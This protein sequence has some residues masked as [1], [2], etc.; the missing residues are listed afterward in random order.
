MPKKLKGYQQVQ[1]A[2]SQAVKK[3]LSQL[4]INYDTSFCKSLYFLTLRLT[5][6]LLMPHWPAYCPCYN[7]IFR[8]GG[9]FKPLPSGYCTK[10]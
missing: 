9:G 1:V 5:L 4:K 7:P 6:M 3:T 2:D 8:A 10:A